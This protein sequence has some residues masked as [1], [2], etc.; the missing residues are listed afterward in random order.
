MSAAPFLAPAAALRDV[1]RGVLRFPREDLGRA[2]GDGPSRYVVF[3]HM[4]RTAAGHG[5]Q[6]APCVF[7][8][9]GEFKTVGRRKNRRLSAIPVP[10][11]AVQP[12]FLSKRWAMGRETGGIMGR[13]E[14]TTRD[15]ALD[16][17]DSFPMKMMRS[18]VRPET[19][20]CRIDGEAYFGR[21]GGP[22]GR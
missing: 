8:V 5:G 19:F 17:Y 13:Y 9:T 12:G 7:E 10:F 20:R 21:T 6:G 14:W 3:R 4:T 11:I 22:S 1:V 18:R 2:I 16:Y 15:D